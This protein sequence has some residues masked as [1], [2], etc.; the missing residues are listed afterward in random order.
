MDLALLCLCL[1]ANE[2]LTTVHMIGNLTDSLDD[3]GFS[4]GFESNQVT[5]I[6]SQL[7]ANT[8][9]SGYNTNTV[10]RDALVCI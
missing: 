5:T 9:Q 1:V 8:H 7:D 2:G 3:S 6:R 4:V 10:R